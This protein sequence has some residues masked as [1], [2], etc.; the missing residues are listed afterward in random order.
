MKRQLRAGGTVLVS[1]S[2]NE[3]LRER[4]DTFTYRTASGTEYKV[5]TLCQMEFPPR[6]A[7]ARERVESDMERDRR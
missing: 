5:V 3:V 7:A 2:R 4:Y 1:I 6:R